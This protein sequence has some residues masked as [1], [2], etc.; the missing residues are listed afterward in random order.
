M[1]ARML[2]MLFLAMVGVGS[3]GAEAFDFAAWRGR[4]DPAIDRGLAYLISQQNE[5][6]SFGQNYGKTTAIPALVGMAFL[7]KGYQ[8]SGGPHA[9]V[10]TRCVDFVLNHQ[11]ETGMLTAENRGNGP[12]YGH[13]I[14]TLFLSEVSGMVDPVRQERINK[15]LKSALQ[16][17]LKAQ[18]VEKQEQYRGGW[19]Y[20]PNSYDSDL[21]C[22]GWALMALRS[23][24][25]NGAAV[26][27]E[28]ITK[29]LNYVLSLQDKKL[30]CFGYMN[31][32]SHRETLTGMGLLCLELCGMHGKPETIKAADFIM[33]D[34]R[35][36]PG[37]EYETYGNYYN[38][39]AMFQ[40]GGRYWDTYGSWMYGQYLGKQREDGSWEASEAG[41]VYAT[42]MMVLAFSVPYRQLPIYQRDETS[43]EK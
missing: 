31:T 37:R 8:P 19:R 4:I 26:P 29:A 22:S 12:M 20:H 17:I 30:G 21:S 18:A 11:M 10:I 9:E 3:A 23:A 24:K 5:D 2:L 36:L 33:G 41:P 39:Q 16:V 40:M 25:G 35:Q 28:A 13:N 15:T 27:D 6:G 34:F 42:S 7:S 1:K 32:E 43:D 14:S 38:A